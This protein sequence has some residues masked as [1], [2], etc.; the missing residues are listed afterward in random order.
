MLQIMNSMAFDPNL[1]TDPEYPPMV[2]EPTTKS[3]IGI[4][5]V[6]IM[7]SIMASKI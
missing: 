7:N 6:T 3:Q 1:V 2:V 4:V 5:C